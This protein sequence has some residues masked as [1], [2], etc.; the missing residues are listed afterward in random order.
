MYAQGVFLIA[1]C[2][3]I[4]AVSGQH[5]PASA[6]HEAYKKYNHK[7]YTEAI[8]LFEEALKQYPEED[9]LAYS[10][11]GY[12]YYSEKKY[13]K[14]IQ[15]YEYSLHNFPDINTGH[16]IRMLAFCY[17]DVANYEKS[18]EYCELYNSLMEQLKKWNIF[19]KENE[20]N[21]QTIVYLRKKNE[22]EL[23]SIKVRNQLKT[24]PIQAKI[25][26]LST[27]NDITDDIAP[28]L[29]CDE[30]SLYFTSYRK[31]EKASYN[32]YTEQWDGNIF[33]SNSYNNGF[34]W[35]VPINIHS[36]INT[37]NQEGPCT[38]TADGNTMYYYTWFETTG[39][40]I[41]ESKSE[42]GVWSKPR[43]LPDVINTNLWESQPTI[44][45]DG[46]LLIFVRSEGYA[47][48]SDLW[49]SVKDA[50]GKWTEAKNMGNTIN[51]SMS[52]MSPYLHIDGKTLYFSSNGHPTMGGYDI[53]KSVLQP[54]GTWSRPENI[55]YPINSEKDDQY[56]VLNASGTKGYFSSNKDNPK[57]K[58]NLYQAELPEEFRTLQTMVISG[59]IK[60]EGNDTPLVCKIQIE[61]LNTHKIVQ[62]IYSNSN[63][64]FSLVLGQGKKYGIKIEK[65]NYESKYAVFEVNKNFQSIKKIIKLRSIE[66]PGGLDLRKK[67]ELSGF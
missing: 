57:N 27:L 15:V 58:M 39:G 40:D 23:K 21:E 52:E 53:F 47:Q 61:D 64:K 62:T 42:N 35:S 8:P 18:M 66:K 32:S 24:N 29:T 37:T 67:D 33:V 10:C 59:Y 6:Y 12:A 1:F 41:A 3:C 22:Q 5:S 49:Y 56:F 16:C 50:S 26:P 28:Y 14:A 31:R 45:P 43:R 63:G 19:S 7:K 54:D 20:E 38:I 9:K 13:D 65:K 36:N 25:T 51:T 2:L 17:N 48:P 55:G 4:N 11:L 34:S 60:D 44:S 30:N 46:N